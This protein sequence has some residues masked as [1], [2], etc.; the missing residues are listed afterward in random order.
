[1]AYHWPGEKWQHGF[2][3]FKEGEK[4]VTLGQK[5]TELAKSPAAVHQPERA[6]TLLDDPIVNDTAGLNAVSPPAMAQF[7]TVF[8][9]IPESC[10]H[11][12]AAYQAL[13]KEIQAGSRMSWARFVW[14]MHALWVC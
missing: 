13:E 9:S 3:A 5:V 1:M 6:D 11:N 2:G 7:E 12:R 4:T 10:V 8:S 14:A